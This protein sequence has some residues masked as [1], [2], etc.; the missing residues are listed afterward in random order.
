M[1]QREQRETV[2]ITAEGRMKGRRDPLEEGR[3]QK[4]EAVKWVISGEL[5]HRHDE[6]V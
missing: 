4:A 5:T 3:D 2:A 6:G 1:L